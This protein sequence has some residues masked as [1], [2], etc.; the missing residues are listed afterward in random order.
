V[1]EE[2]PPTQQ[3]P[4]PQPEGGGNR[5]RR[6][7]RSR[8]DRMIAGVAGGLGDYFGVDP[9][10]IRIGFGV[11]L[12]FGGLGALAY[13]ALALFVPDEE[14]GAPAFPRSRTLTIAGIIVLIAIATPLAGFGIFHH[15]HLLGALWLLVPIGLAV[16]VYA[17]LRERHTAITPLRVLGAVIL[18]SIAAAGLLALSAVAAFATATGHGLAVALLVVAGG[19]II[20]AAALRGG[21]RILIAPALALAL[22]VGFAAAADLNFRGGIGDRTY[23]PTAARTIPGDGYRLGVGRLAVD[24][25]GLP[26]KPGTVLRLKAHLG[27]GELEVAVPSRVCVDASAHVGAG[28]SRVLGQQADGFDVDNDQNTGTSAKP[29]LVLDASVD[30]GELRVINDDDADIDA[31]G[32]FFGISDDALRQASTRACAA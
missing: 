1:T 20:A 9:V 15:G 29:R 16:A 25:R 30:A 8:R 31:H 27:A 21:A 17:V 13:L 26:W 11:S 18:V 12:F 5:P 23:A 14:G 4:E 19:A 7:L 22:G 24:L 2:T 28:D 3:I 10:I 6:L 32:P